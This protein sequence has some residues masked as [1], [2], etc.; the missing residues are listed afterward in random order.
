[1]LWTQTKSGRDQYKISG[2][3]WTDHGLSRFVTV[4]PTNVIVLSGKINNS[5]R[6]V[7]I[8]NCIWP[9]ST[10]MRIFQIEDACGCFSISGKIR[11]ISDRFQQMQPKSSVNGDVTVFWLHYWS[12]SR[13]RSSGKETLDIYIY[14]NN[15]N[16]LRKTSE[17][18]ALHSVPLPIN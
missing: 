11:W 17:R 15:N 7:T 9:W 18:S 5:S 3:S 4:F 10:R 8:L 6:F 14:K 2:Q 13:H 12:I 16:C 1:M